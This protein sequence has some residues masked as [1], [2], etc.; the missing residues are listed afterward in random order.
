MTALRETVARAIR[1]QK[2]AGYRYGKED[3]DQ[4]VEMHWR[5]DLPEA[6]A[7]LDTLRAA[8]L[9]ATADALEDLYRATVRP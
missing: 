5:Q 4:I 7:A 9:K 2:T 8:G 1:K 3:T 6:D